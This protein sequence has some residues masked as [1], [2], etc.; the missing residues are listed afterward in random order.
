M[1]LAAALALVLVIEGLA[2]AVLARSLP[3]VLAAVE[4]IDPTQ[5]RLIGIVMLVLGSLCYVAV[6]G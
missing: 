1:D 6:R 2:L 4:A 3:E 5:M